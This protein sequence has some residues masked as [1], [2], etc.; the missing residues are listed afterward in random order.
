MPVDG[1][2]LIQNIYCFKIKKWIEIFIGFN[3][4]KKKFKISLPLFANKPEEFIQE[5]YFY[6]LL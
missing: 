3:H 4:K 2:K 6:N 5:A 1:L